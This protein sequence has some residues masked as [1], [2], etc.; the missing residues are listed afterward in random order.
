M[1]NFY[2]LLVATIILMITVNPALATFTDVTAQNP[3]AKAIEW[4]GSI[5]VGNDSGQFNP[6]RPITRA[7]FLTMGLLAAGVDASKLDKNSRT[8]F[9]DVPVES[10][11]APYVAE[12]E[13]FGMLSDY[14]D[15]FGPE[16]VLTRGEA[17]RL[18]LAL[19]GVGTPPTIVEE[20]FGFRDVPSRHMYAPYVYRA[21]KADV[22][23]PVAD[24]KFGVNQALTRAGA[25]ELFYKL[26]NFNEG[27]VVVVQTSRSSV[28]PNNELLEIIWNQIT[29]KFLFE[30]QIDETVMIQ[31]AAKGI[32][33]SLGDPYSN[34]FTPEAS[35]A[36]SDGLSGEVEG[37]GAYLS[38]DEKTGDVVIVSPIKGS[39]A[40]E[41][42][43][44]P[45]DVIT[46]VG[47]KSV[48]GM[49]VSEVAGRIKGPTGTDI[50]ITIRRNGQTQSFI[51]TR[52]RV[53]VKSVELTFN[54]N[55]AVVSISQFGV[56][57]AEEFGKA[58][59]EIIAQKPK[60]IV[61]DLRNNPGGLLNT[62]IDMLG[63]FLPNGSVAAT[64]RYR[65]PSNDT[66]YRTN[67]TPL[68]DGYRTLVL[69]NKG[70]ASASEIVAGA[71]QD[72]NVAA[73]VGSQ[74]FGKGTVQ[75]LSF[76]SDGTALKLT[77]AH[78]LSPN[79][80]PIQGNGITPDIA[81]AED[82]NTA[83]DEVMQKA[84]EWF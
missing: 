67:R 23:A 78:W 40:E 79:F 48:K 36:F 75:E 53:E 2:R 58:A 81:V 73:I 71:L 65:D 31:A 33:D 51:V 14:R 70:S 19:F 18:G 43:L 62:A 7:E 13:R 60:G 15:K 25:A 52:A 10:W 27:S 1:S 61:L 32:V 72:H 22:M 68:L 44:K 83:A 41:A 4:L 38:E 29:S 45:D 66:V 30:N 28:I 47:G 56:T 57:T 6:K 11:F 80:Q 59:A 21:V 24:G 84:L 35:N 77:I 9:N 3:Q 50:Q 5:G 55:I 63:Y 46:A 17:A 64:A 49:T 37:I 39:P 16:R 8:R 54:N 42:G 69:V 74:S 12:A 82:E 76:F 34:F 20:Y 26:D